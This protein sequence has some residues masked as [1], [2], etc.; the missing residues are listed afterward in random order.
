MCDR[1][2]PFGRRRLPRVRGLR[3]RGSR[4]ND[5]L[6]DDG[7]TLAQVGHQPRRFHR[8]NPPLDQCGDDFLIWTSGPEK[9]LRQINVRLQNVVCHACKPWAQING[10]HSRHECQRKLRRP[11]G[12][13]PSWHSLPKAQSYLPQ[14]V[15]RTQRRKGM[16]SDYRATGSVCSTVCS[17]LCS[18]RLYRFLRTIEGNGGE[19]ATEF[20]GAMFAKPTQAVAAA[21][22]IPAAALVAAS[23]QSAAVVR[24]GCQRRSAET[25]LRR[26]RISHVGQ[27]AA[28]PARP[29]HPSRA[30]WPRPNPPPQP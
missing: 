7:L 5:S 6:R 8:V 3:G 17:C 4:E 2:L 24:K 23:R 19:R 20:A 22:P 11:L 26:A 29:G 1:A 30:A 13:G 18:L 27:K 15:Q 21:G 12:Q 28:S 25:P 16:V 14:R 10:A 9:L